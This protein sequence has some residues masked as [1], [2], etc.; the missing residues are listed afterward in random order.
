MYQ[1]KDER[2]IT[3][4]VKSEARKWLY[5]NLDKYIFQNQKA[6][7]LSMRIST[8]R[9]VTEETYKE[10]AN[11]FENNPINRKVGGLSEGEKS[12]VSDDLFKYFINYNNH[13]LPLGF[14]IDFFEDDYEDKECVKKLISDFLAAA[15]VHTKE[16]WGGIRFTFGQALK[17][18][19]SKLVS[20]YKCGILHYI[21]FAFMAVFFMLLVSSFLGFLSD[22]QLF[23]TMW[24]FL[25]VNRFETTAA[26]TTDASAIGL[27]GTFDIGEYVSAVGVRWLN[28]VIFLYILMKISPIIRETKYIFMST[29]IQ[30]RIFMHERVA[31]NC[32]DNGSDMLEE[33][34]NELIAECALQPNDIASINPL[35]SVIKLFSKLFR[36]NLRLNPKNK[37]S[38]DKYNNMDNSK[39]FNTSAAR[40][41]WL[42]ILLIVSYVI[43]TEALWDLIMGLFEQ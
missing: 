13:D 16:A 5:T 42:V 1:L 38:Y 24:E 39:G 41:V 40:M 31:Q 35:P 9:K 3:N 30:I 43:N 22:T 36:Y 7:E 29:L 27:K 14:I 17:D 18:K 32:E 25:I 20:I 37:N 10:F 2:R 19:K 11:M 15:G 21:K 12:I 6:R 8:E 23:G 33:L 28:L 4:F 26:L 34:S